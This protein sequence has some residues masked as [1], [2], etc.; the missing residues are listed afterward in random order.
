[1]TGK[2]NNA[3]LEILKVFSKPISDTQ[4]KELKCLLFQFK[5]RQTV[6]DM[7]KH[8]EE[9]GIYPDDLLKEHMR[10]PYK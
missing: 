9:Q 8:W 10:T 6:K 7:D 4:L 5:A 1:M 3:Q 2:L